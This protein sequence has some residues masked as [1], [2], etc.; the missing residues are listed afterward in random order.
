MKIFYSD[1][2]ALSG[3]SFDTTRKSQWVRDSFK[4]NR[5]PAIKIVAPKSISENDV[6]K[7][8]DEKY[9]KAIITGKPRR[10]AESQGFKWD[11]SFWDMV[12]SSTGGMIEAMK[13]AIEDGIAGTLSSGIHHARKN[14]GKGYCTINGLALAAKIALER[15][16]KKVLIL[17]LDAHCGGGTYSL[18]YD[19]ARIQHIDV[20]VSKYDRYEIENG[21]T[22]RTL[23][24]VSSHKRYLDTIRKRLEELVGDEPKLCLYNA[25]MDPHEN[26]PEGGLAGITAEMLAQRE[27]IV[28][29]FFKEKNIPIA[30]TLAGGYIGPKMTN[31]S[32]VKL[33]RLTIKAATK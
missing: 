5:L 28:F 6:L 16:I 20:S 11:N 23:D 10:L 1:K 31:N 2:Y 7:I 32:L 25:G 26:C 19:D 22:L 18:I 33:H 21:K 29:S 3:H 15:G 12:S 17:D 9:V 27:K 14:R 24:I 8:H 13:E 30:F 4:K